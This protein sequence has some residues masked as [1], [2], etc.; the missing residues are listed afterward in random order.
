[1]W[2]SIAQEMNCTWREAE[3][4]HWRLGEDELADRAGGRFVGAQGDAVAKRT[5]ALWL[6]RGEGCVGW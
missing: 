5:E 1:M 6:A 2:T 4:M 3:A